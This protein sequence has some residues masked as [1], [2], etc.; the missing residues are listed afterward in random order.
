MSMLERK[1]LDIQNSFSTSNNSNIFS[2][3]KLGERQIQT[4]NVSLMF[5]DSAVQNIDSL[6]KNIAD[7]TIAIVLDRDE[8]GIEQITKALGY[9]DSI[10]SLHLVSHGHDGEFQLGSTTLNS[11][12]IAYYKDKLELW[13]SSFTEDADTL[14]Y[15]CNVAGDYIG[16]GIYSGDPLLG[17]LS[18]YTGTDVSA[19]TDFTGSSE[20][21][22]DWLLER[23][24]GDIESQYSGQN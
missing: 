10:P 17:Q 5:I 4:S 20:L 11:S 23:I 14:V 9:F 19:S 21:G 12:N 15:G 18:H 24:I 1:T 6:I 2:I 8:D 16:D 3:G 22:G 7:N 13:K